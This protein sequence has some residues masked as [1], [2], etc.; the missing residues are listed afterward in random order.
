MN[1]A[2]SSGF[3]HLYIYCSAPLGAFL[4]VKLHP[5]TLFQCVKIH[6]LQSGAVE[7][8]FTSI[9]SA[10]EA[11]APSSDKS[12]YST[13]QTFTSYLYKNSPSLH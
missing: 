11:E 13:F 4:Y 8:D 1:L 10:D 5:I 12:L 9:F 2:P 7:E 3:Y 6:T